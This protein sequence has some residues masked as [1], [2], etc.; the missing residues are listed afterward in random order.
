MD[1]ESKTASEKSEV[2]GRSE[3]VKTS[4]GKWDRAQ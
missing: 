1:E 2:S 3:A 4:T